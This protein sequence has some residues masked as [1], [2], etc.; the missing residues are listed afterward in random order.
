M[1]M[2][3]LAASI[4]AVAAALST[5]ACGDDGD[6]S[7]CDIPI[8]TSPGPTMRPGQNCL[9]CHQD[10]F[11]DPNAPEFTA[12]GTVFPAIDSEFCEGVEGATLTFKKMDGTDLV[13]T[14]N[15]VGNFWTTE[16]IQPTGPTIEY[17]GRTLAMNRDLPAIAACNACHSNPPVGGAPGKIYVP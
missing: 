7:V 17:Q 2:K 12:A 6:E 4:V 5:A 14:T 11:G 16:A 10:G 1:N 8:N 15:S 3:L 13:L 9:D